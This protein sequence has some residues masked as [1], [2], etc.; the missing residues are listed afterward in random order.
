MK[1]ALFVLLVGIL[2]FTALCYFDTLKFRRHFPAGLS[3]GK[4]IR[5][6]S[7]FSS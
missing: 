7:N 6:N 1:K 2:G 3:V 5:L 4:W